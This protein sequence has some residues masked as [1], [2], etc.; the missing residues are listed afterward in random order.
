MYMYFQEGVREYWGM[1]SHAKQIWDDTDESY[2]SKIYERFMATSNGIY[3]M[4]P[5]TRMNE[6]YDH[7]ITDWFNGALSV[8]DTLLLTPPRSNEYGRCDV[9]TM[10]H[11]I[12]EGK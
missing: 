6:D 8:K 3:T 9:I 11:T 1:F 10:A 2:S 4:F 7:M 12:L 5:A